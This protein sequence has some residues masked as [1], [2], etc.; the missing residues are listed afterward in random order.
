[1]LNNK[2]EVNKFISDYKKSTDLATDS[3]AKFANTYF[4]P[5]F[6]KA[7]LLANFVF[8]SKNKPEAF[9]NED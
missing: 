1:M 3:N 2:N 6:T 8:F 5:Q 9:F 7:N 4:L